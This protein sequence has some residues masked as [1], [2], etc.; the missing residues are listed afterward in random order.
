MKLDI[1]TEKTQ[2]Q[3]Y[4]KA[5]GGKPNSIAKRKHSAVM[6]QLAAKRVSDFCIKGT[7]D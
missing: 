4:L 6:K 1:K 3:R 2:W 7:R 5:C